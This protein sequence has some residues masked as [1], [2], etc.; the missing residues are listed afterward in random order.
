MIK[1]APPNLARIDD[2]QLSGRVLLFTT[3]ITLLTGLMFGLLPAWSATRTKPAIVFSQR[4]STSG[5]LRRR[6]FDGLLV[7]EI[8]LALMVV[9]GAG[10]MTRTMYKI[11]H[12]DPGFQSDHVLA[13]RLDVQD[14]KY[15]ATKLE[16]FRRDV[17]TNVKAIPGVESAALTLSLPIEG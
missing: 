7:A 12:V 5:P 16:S 13:M 11:A 15:N 9:T 14:P 17:L 1:L 6:L 8:A 4:S 3:G 2:V 10:L